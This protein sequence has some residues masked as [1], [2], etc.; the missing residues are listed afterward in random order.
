MARLVVA[1]LAL[2][3]ASSPGQAAKRVAL[4]IGNAAYKNATTLTNT[5]NDATDMSAALRKVGFQVIEGLDLDKAATERKIGEFAIALDGADAGIF[6]YSGHGL[7]VAGQNYIV[8]IDAGLLTPAALEL[9]M[10]RLDTIQRIMERQSNTNILFLDACRNNPLARNLAKVMGTRAAQIGTGLAATQGGVGTLIAYSTQPDN[11]ALDGTGGRNSPF[12]GPLAKHIAR[13]GEDLNSILISVRKDVVTATQGKQVPWEHS[14]LMGRFYFIPPAPAHVAPAAA[15]S[16]PVD[17]ALFSGE[18]LKRIAALAARKKIPIKAEIKMFTPAVGVPES[19]RAL[20]GVW[21]SDTGY[22][23]TNR[24]AMLVIVDI[25]KAG[26]V[27]GY[28]A[29]GPPTD[30]STI[31]AG[32]G[33]WPFVGVLKDR[34]IKITTGFGD[35]SIVFDTL[36]RATQT[37]T[38]KNG[39]IGKVMLKPAWTLADA[40]RARKAP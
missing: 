27:T 18:E 37:D 31:K 13:P 17:P 4:V 40:E 25:S 38:F 14:A 8:P 12:T 20:I 32:A 9:E 29:Q 6:F 19:V 21:F 26:L 33:F 35:I 28:R 24:Q 2:I 3:L 10:V 1:L 16:T 15:T 5:L 7:Q 23:R 30:K 36:N 34:T 22:E 11:V 39:I